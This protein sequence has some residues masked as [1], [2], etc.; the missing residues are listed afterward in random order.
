MKIVEPAV[1]TPKEGEPAPKSLDDHLRETLRIHRMDP[2]PTFLYFHHPHEDIEK[3]GAAGVASKKLCEMLGEDDFA[4]WGSL[5]KCFEVDVSKSDPKLLERLGAG[6]GPSFALVDERLQVVAKSGAFP[7]AKA[8]AAF[9]KQTVTT[10]FTEYWKAVQERVGEQGKALTEARALAKAK[11]YA[12][13]IGQY[14]LIRYSD[15][16]VADFFDDAV[17][18]ASEVEAKAAKAAKE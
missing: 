10:S 16:Q 4:R 2:R 1:V 8:A 17:R 9:V 18:E 15:L 11:K 14:D 3:P 13:A 5:V 12:E 7:T 6:K